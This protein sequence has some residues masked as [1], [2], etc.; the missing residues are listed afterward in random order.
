[1]TTKPKF[2]VSANEQGIVAIVVT[3]I[4]LIVI[5]LTALGLAALARRESR[6]ALDNQLSTQA[7]YLAQAGIND[8]SRAI[9]TTGSYHSTNNRESCRE[10]QNRLLA[11]SQLDFLSFANANQTNG[12]DANAKFISGLLGNLTI[13][14][15]SYSCVLITHD[16]ETLEYDIS[17]DK[18]KFAE[19]TVVDNAGNP[20]NNYDLIISWEA[21][22]GTNGFDT[23]QYP[24]FPTK[25][26]WDAAGITTGIMR[27]DITALGNNFTR[28]TITTNTM[29]SFLYPSTGGGASQS[30]TDNNSWTGKGSILQGNCSNSHPNFPR[31]CNVTINNIGNSHIFLR[32]KSIYNDSRVTISARSGAASYRLKGAQVVIDS[33]GKAADV[34]RRVQVRVPGP[35]RSSAEY[36]VETVEGICKRLAATPGNTTFNT[37]TPIGDR[38]QD[39]CDPSKH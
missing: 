32:L 29:T 18:S 37:V 33:T 23:S 17:T 16:P 22:D 11:P 21:R 1:M 27:A 39:V 31:R 25:A 6:Q 28:D 15:A 7:Y 4:F 2:R 14:N 3:L 36:V 8:A 35:E 13:D 24:N 20:V 12:T 30:F 26:G 10:D 5:S 9:N 19:L 34:V 38:D